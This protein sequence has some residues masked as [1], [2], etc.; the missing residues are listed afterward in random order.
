MGKEPVYSKYLMKFLQSYQVEGVPV[1]AIT[2]QNEVDTDQD[3][4]MPACVWA[5]EHEIVLVSQHL[6]PLSREPGSGNDAAPGE[7]QPVR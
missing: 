2:P 4:R 7:Y 6:G 5:Q 1:D 3:G